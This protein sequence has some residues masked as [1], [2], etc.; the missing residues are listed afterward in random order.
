MSSRRTPLAL[1]GACLAAAALVTVLLPTTAV[2]SAGTAATGV[3][4]ARVADPSQDRPTLPA[5]CRPDSEQHITKPAPC[6]V[7]RFVRT[8]PTLMLW[9]DSHAYHHIPAVRA[10]IRGQNVNLVLFIAGACPPMVRLVK[11]QD[12]CSSINRQALEFVTRLHK[13]DRPL[14]VLLGAYWH[15]YL[16]TL[17]KIDAGEEPEADEAYIFEQSREFRG[18]VPRMFRTLGRMR[19]DADVLGPVPTVPDQV[20]PCLLGETPYACPIPRG[21]ALPDEGTTREY[22]ETQM[23][24]LHGRPRLVNLK[25]RVCDS[26]FCYGLRDDVYTWYDGIHLSA[27][28]SRTTTSAF[29]GIVR[30][31]KR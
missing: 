12:T 4:A 2:G 13:N 8:R 14:T 23:E 31:L 10:A 7:T 5:R 18:G 30:D 11:Q 3:V 24:S 25:P 19:V 27:T 26:A 21:Q 29:R 6:Y 17:E 1:L 22:V 16:S 15:W 9:G 20:A 28:F